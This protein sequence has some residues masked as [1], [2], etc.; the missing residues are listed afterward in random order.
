MESMKKL[1]LPILL[2]AAALLFYHF[3]LYRIDG[4]SMNYG[5]IEGDLVLTQRRFGTIHRG[6]LLVFQNPL[7]HDDTLYIK[8]CVALPGDRFFE[9]DRSF[10]LQIESNGTKTTRLAQTYDLEAVRTRHGIFLKD[11]Y[12]KYYGVVH[13]RRLTVPRVLTELPPTTLPA[14]TYY[15]LGDYRDNS[16]DSRFFGPVPR[17]LIYS[18][19]IRIVKKAHSWRDLTAIEEADKAR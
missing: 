8:R 1:S 4:T 13:N 12:L 6:D 15:M 10:Y 19:V 11:P 14:D 18:K 2:V 3:R 5:L 16:A 9:R 17:R 7:V